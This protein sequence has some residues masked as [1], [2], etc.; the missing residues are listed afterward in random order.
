[1]T[2]IIFNSCI[3]LCLLNFQHVVGMEEFELF[4]RDPIAQGDR[5]DL[6]ATCS[7]GDRLS[8]PYR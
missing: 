3:F 1:M 5:F 2:E 6:T 8:L 7:Q 4:V